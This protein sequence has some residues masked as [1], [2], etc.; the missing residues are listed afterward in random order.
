MRMRFL[1]LGS[2]FMLVGSLIWL[3]GI[4]AGQSRAD[5]APSLSRGVGSTVEPFSLT[6]ALNGQVVD[7]GQAAGEKATVLVFLGTDCPIGNLYLPRLVELEKQYR[8]QGVALFGINSNASESIAQV[9][10]E[11][12]LNTA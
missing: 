8:G 6:N 11:C 9:A 1:R 7:L 2:R 12:R 5:D 4:S 3:L 10:A